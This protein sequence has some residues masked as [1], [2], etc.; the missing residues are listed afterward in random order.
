L[1]YRQRTDW[2]GAV[3]VGKRFCTP[4]LRRKRGLFDPANESK[5]RQNRDDILNIYGKGCEYGSIDILLGFGGSLFLYLWDFDRCRVYIAKGQFHARMHPGLRR[6]ISGLRRKGSNGSSK[7]TR[8]PHNSIP[9]QLKQTP[10]VTMGNPLSKF[11]ATMATM[12]TNMIPPR[13][14][15]RRPLVDDPMDL[16]RALPANIVANHIY[17]FVTRVIEDRDQLIKAV[18]EYFNMSRRNRR[19]YPMSHWDVT[20][21]TDFSGVFD[22]TCNRKLKKINEDLS[23]WNVVNGTTFERM[24]NECRKFKSDLS[25][26]KVGNATNLSWMFYRCRSFRSDVAGW[27]VANVTNLSWMFCGCSSFHSDVSRWN[28]ANAILLNSMFWDCH[29]FHSDVSGWNVSNAILLSHMFRG[30]TSFQSDVSRWNVANAT[31]L[32][33]MFLGCTSF[34]SDVSGWNVANATDLIDMFYGCTSF[35]GPGWQ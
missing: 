30:C 19:R 16:L 2:D 34:Q 29:S 8:K 9:A 28:V 25:R 3:F 15:K 32:N 23:S 11:A 7:I 17:P 27:N 4:F 35:H 26:W 20:A 1:R 14:R 31:H 10:T 18:D 13:R 5:D 33:S 24:F 21:V 6:I 12:G 22:A